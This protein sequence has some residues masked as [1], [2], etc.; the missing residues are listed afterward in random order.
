MKLCRTSTSASCHPLLEKFFSIVSSVV[1][2][3]EEKNGFQKMH[4]VESV[5]NWNK[6]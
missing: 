4:S 2:S 6:S 3:A 5:L 1:L